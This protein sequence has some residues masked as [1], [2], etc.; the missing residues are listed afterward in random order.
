MCDLEKGQDAA[1][2]TLE[3]A[4]IAAAGGLESNSGESCGV[5]GD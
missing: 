3:E 1:P 4:E 5:H 2:L